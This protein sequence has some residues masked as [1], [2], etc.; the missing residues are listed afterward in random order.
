MSS[1]KIVPRKKKMT[2]SES[3][4]LT[5][6]RIVGNQQDILQKWLRRRDV[7]HQHRSPAASGY[8]TLIRH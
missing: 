6:A 2:I 7:R 8:P 1:P 4:L 5:V 3:A